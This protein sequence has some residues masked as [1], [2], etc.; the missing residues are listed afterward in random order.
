M[1]DNVWYGLIFAV[2]F[3][4]VIF[5]IWEDVWE[6]YKY[7][8]HTEMFRDSLMRSQQKNYKYTE[9]FRNSLMRYQHDKNTM[10]SIDGYCALYP[11][12]ENYIRQ[13]VKSSEKSS[14]LLWQDEP[15]N[16]GGPWDGNCVL[17]MIVDHRN[18]PL[19]PMDKYTDIP[20]T[21]CPFSVRLYGNDDTSYSAFVA[22]QSKAEEICK[23][24]IESPTWENIAKLGFVFT[25]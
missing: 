18:L 22:T 23:K 16:W 9:M 1:T 2:S 25:N 24:I 10:L 3:S 5:I 19:L 8:R 15:E 11:N 4:F 6:N 13:L 17:L 12:M 7:K 20:T 21:E 14:F